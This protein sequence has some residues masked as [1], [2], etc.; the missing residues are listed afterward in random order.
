MECNE[1]VM[2]ELI[3]TKIHTDTNARSHESTPTNEFIQYMT[4][5]HFPSKSM[6]VHM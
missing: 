1:N 3:N 4:T 2:N 6:P 5:T